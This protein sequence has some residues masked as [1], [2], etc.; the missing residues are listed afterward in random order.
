MSNFR[1]QI[2][3]I[4]TLLSSNTKS[5]KTIAYSTLLH[6]QEQAT[7]DHSLVQLLA[8]SSHPLLSLIVVDINDDDE[9][10]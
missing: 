2:E 3:E 1:D 10:M 8:D 4:K 7:T 6:L 9:E 5:N